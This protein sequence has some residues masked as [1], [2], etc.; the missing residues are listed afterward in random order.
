M[1]RRGAA[2]ITSRASPPLPTS[3]SVPFGI[4]SPI[5]RPR[6]TRNDKN[7]WQKLDI[8]RSERQ[9]VTRPLCPEIPSENYCGQDRATGRRTRLS[10][11]H[12]SRGGDI[13]DTGP[14]IYA[15]FVANGG[16]GCTPEDEGREL[17]SG[18]KFPLIRIA[19]VVGRYENGK[20]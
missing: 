6:L 5:N 14:L 19:S 7:P 12:I 2:L 13:S 4:S 17:I 11:R 20:R 18:S 16:G 10:R 8:W 3:H 9:R 15:S 1:T